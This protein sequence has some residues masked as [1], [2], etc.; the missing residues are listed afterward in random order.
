MIPRA[1]PRLVT[2]AL[3]HCWEIRLASMP[4]TDSVH[5]RFT[6]HAPL[7][8]DHGTAVEIEWMGGRKVDS[9]INGVPT[10]YTQCTR[11]IRS[12]EGAT[13]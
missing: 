10:P 5:A 13:S 9:T 7:S 6:L 1:L 12:P 11:L 4:S 8:S 2:D 3:T